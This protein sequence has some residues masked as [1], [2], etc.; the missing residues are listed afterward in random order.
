MWNFLSMLGGI[1]GLFCYS[2]ILLVG[3]NIMVEFIVFF[4]C[5]VF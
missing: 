3:E 5:S 2:K 1:L 4:F